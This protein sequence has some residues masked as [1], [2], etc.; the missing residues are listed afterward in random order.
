MTRDELYMWL[1]A[2]RSALRQYTFVMLP[3]SSN[4]YT[5]GVTLDTLASENMQI[6]RKTRCHKCG[7]S[8][9]LA[10]GLFEDGEHLAPGG[11]HE[12]TNTSSSSGLLAQYWSW[13]HSNGRRR[14][15]LAA[16]PVVLDH[17][18]GSPPSGGFSPMQPGISR[19]YGVG[20]QADSPHVTVGPHR[21]N[22]GRD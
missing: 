1:C 7:C 3:S 18:P 22:V 12:Y 5:L 11:R 15:D 20:H 10:E 14:A 13:D 16:Q 4:A 21:V 19:R 8:R 17:E 6:T 9:R 2:E